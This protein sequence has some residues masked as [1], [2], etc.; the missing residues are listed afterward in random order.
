[1]SDL[2]PH[3]HWLAS[4]EGIDALGRTAA[5]RADGLNDL[6]VGERLRAELDPERAALLLTQL[7]LRERAASRFAHPERILLTRAGL[8]QATSEHI[9]RYRAKRLAGSERIIDLCCGIGGDLIA[10]AGLGIPLIVVDLDP[11]H[12]FLAE[13]N[14]RA[15]HPDAEI[16]PI[17]ADVR[18]IEIS[19]GDTVFIDP[20]RRLE[21]GKR[22]GYQSEPPVEWSLALADHAMQVAIK[23]AP[24]IPHDLL[25]EGWEMEHIALGSELK[26]AVLWSPALAGE[27]AHAHHAY[28]HRA[29][30]ILNG[31][32]HSINGSHIDVVTTVEPQ[33]GQ[34]LHDVNPAVTNAGLV[35]ELAEALRAHLIDPEIGFLVSEHDARSPFCTSWHILDV[36]PWHEKRIKQALKALDAGPVD[37]RR[38]GLPGDVP[39]ITKRLRGTGNRRVIIAMTRVNEEPTAII[40]AL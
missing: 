6:K 17:L 35:R 39:A 22:T 13:H 34:W 8:E 40:C 18:D 1:M 2:L 33:P 26:E 5:M 10:M 19:P 36:L 20:A 9:A 3:Y 21:S 28:P 23:A 24:G 37:I 14:A 25:P 32:P 30:V 16:T 7:D 27:Y 38:R 4:I 29:T 11:V 31:E 12:L 15:F